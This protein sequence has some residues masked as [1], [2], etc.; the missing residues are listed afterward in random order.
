MDL[1]KGFVNPPSEYRPIPWWCWNGDMDEGEME[2]QMKEFLDKG[3]PEVFIQPLFG[4]EVEYLS[5][6]WWDKFNFVIKKAE[7][8][9]MRI[10]LYDEYCW[11]SGTCGG[12]LLRDKPWVRNVVLGGKM[13]KT[14]KGKTID[15]GF[16]GDVFSVKATLENGKTKDIDDYS[17]KE[18]LEG[19]RIVWKNNLDQDCTLLVFAKRVTKP[20]LP[21]C[22]GSPWTWDQQGYLNT[23]NP[24]AVKAF[25]DYTYEEYARRFASYFGNLIPGVFTD[26]PQ[27]FTLE[28]FKEEEVYLPFTEG[29]FESFQKKRGYDLKDKLHELI[30][31]VGDYLKVRYDY[32]SLVTEIF[33]TS[34]SKQIHDWCDKHHLKY[35]GHFLFEETLHR[36]T[37]HEGDIYQSAKWEHIPGIDLLGRDTSYSEKKNLPYYG[38]PRSLNISAKL[39]SS[40]AVHNGSQRVLCEAFGAQGWDLTMEDMKRI[41]DWLCALGINLINVNKLLYTVRGFRK[42][43]VSVDIFFTIPWWKYYKLY[44]DY[45]A[46]LC[47]TSSVGKAQSKIAVLYPTSS[48]WSMLDIKA[49]KSLFDPKRNRILNPTWQIMQET[50]V[51]ATEAL[52]RKHWPFDYL[53]EEVLLEAKIDKSRLLTDKANY[54]VLILPSIVTLK[55]ELFEK[56]EEF[57]SEGGRVIALDLLPFQSP[58]ENWSMRERIKDIF[59]VDPNTS[60]ERVLEL[61]ERREEKIPSQNPLH[62]DDRKDNA[63][64]LSTIKKEEFEDDLD[65]SLSGFLTKEIE[66]LGQDTRDII[67]SHRVFSNTDIFFFANQS[68]RQIDTKIKLRTKEKVEIWNPES[69]EIS[70]IK[71]EGDDFGTTLSYTFTRYESIFLVTEKGEIDKESS[72]EK[73]IQ[74]QEKILLSDEW[75]F[76]TEKPNMLKLD[77]TVRPD[78]YEKGYQEG[79]YKPDDDEKWVEL[80]EDLLFPEY[81]KLE[82]NR[83]CWVKSKFKM[84]YIPS[85]LF[86]VVDDLIYNEAYINGK[87]LTG[88]QQTVLWDKENIRFK[89]NQYIKTG[90]N[91][92]VARVQLPK[93]WPGARWTPTGIDPIILLG[94]FTAKKEGRIWQINPKIQKIRTG[95]WH[96]Q[97]YPN[98][99]GTAIYEQVVDLPSTEGKVFLK[100]NEVRD[101]LEVWINDKNVSIRPWPPFIVD[102]T[103]YVHEGANKISLKVTNTMQN[104]FRKPRPSGLLDLC[105]I[106]RFPK[107]F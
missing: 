82:E 87:R 91:I 32:W 40:T 43:N 89:I 71:T 15:V 46:R 100:T 8:L 84:N 4:L 18:N 39:I 19:K 106:H 28:S 77:L 3:I 58:D 7:E 83:T 9:G 24:Q 20:V 85:E 79:W 37:V 59:G 42:R 21:S 64:I 29:L 51:S 17:I 6:K 96:E 41:T 1:R 13:L 93:W 23:L 104:L 107:S 101:V 88:A 45:A 52:L 105:I 76:Q 49:S 31:D 25:L 22:T 2:W 47:F 33:S 65:S 97:G 81:L 98:Y 103:D 78:P 34:Y 72:F 66:I 57:I 63:I 14:E 86:L 102:I 75:S 95:S 55:K 5:D 12:F 90:D 44:S 26:E 99:A 30:L 60:N 10:W 80:G 62:K 67:S 50:L 38:D 92:I 11:P 74:S 53:F 27:F 69:G 94:E 73:E 61:W 70:H 36:S 54:S 16:E 68:P 35:T 56:I 48:A